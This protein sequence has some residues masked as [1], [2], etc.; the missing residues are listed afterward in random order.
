MVSIFITCICNFTPNNN[1]NLFQIF[2]N[3]FNNS[4]NK[5]FILWSIFDYLCTYL[6]TL[7]N[8]SKTVPVFYDQEYMICKVGWQK[9]TEKWPQ[10]LSLEVTFFLIKWDQC[11]WDDL[12]EGHLLWWNTRRENTDILARQIVRGHSPI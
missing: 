2:I 11:K 6:T 1:L 9:E 3:L 8:S 12:I 10:A 5:K 7:S 4:N